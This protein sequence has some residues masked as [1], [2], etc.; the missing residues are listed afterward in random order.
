MS[1]QFRMAL[2]GDMIN[3]FGFKDTLRSLIRYRM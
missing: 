1:H 2:S 3:D